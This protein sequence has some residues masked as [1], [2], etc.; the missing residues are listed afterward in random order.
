MMK[1][2]KSRFALDWAGHHGIRHW[3]RVLQQR[4]HH[5][6]YVDGVLTHR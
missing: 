2:I 6:R 4:T 3:A 5:C 1:R